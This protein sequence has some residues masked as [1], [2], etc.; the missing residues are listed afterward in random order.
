MGGASF[1]DRPDVRTSAFDSEVLLLQL[2]PQL[3]PQLLDPPGAQE[4][5]WLQEV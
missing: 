2:V 4:Y 1:I 3:Q 5:R